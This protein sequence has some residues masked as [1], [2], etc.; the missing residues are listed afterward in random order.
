MQNAGGACYAPTE[1]ERR[2]T[3]A[4]EGCVAKRRYH[5]LMVKTFVEHS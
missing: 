1:V 3:A 5:S 2:H 4:V